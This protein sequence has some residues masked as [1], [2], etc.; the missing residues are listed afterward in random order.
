MKKEE[1]A[2]RLD[3]FPYDMDGFWLITGAALV[4]FGVREETEDID[5]GCSTEA[6]NRLEADGHLYQVTEDGKRWFKIHGEFEVFEN[7]LYGSVEQLDGYPVMSL[8]GIREMK[9]RLGRE[10]DLRDI[11][12]I[13]AFVARKDS[14]VSG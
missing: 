13:D 8:Q 11:Q 12:L 3:A 7:W 14:D 5:M 10:K 1:I 6:A 2:A 9:Q 4:L